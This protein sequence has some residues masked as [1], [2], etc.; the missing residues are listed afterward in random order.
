MGQF[1][2]KDCIVDVDEL[3]GSSNNLEQGFDCACNQ[4]VL[5]E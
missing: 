4:S 5:S 1:Q 2:N 3:P